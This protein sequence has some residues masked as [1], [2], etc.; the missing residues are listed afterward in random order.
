MSWIPGIREIIQQPESPIALK[1]RTWAINERKEL[2]HILGSR[3]FDDN[4]D[5]YKQ[6]AVAVL[7]ERDPRFDLPPEE[8]Y[9]ASIHGKVL[10]YSSH[11]RKGLAESLALIGSEPEALS[12]CST[13][14]P[15][16]IATLTIREIFADSD[17]VLWGSLDNLLPL[18]A[19]AAPTEFL[20]VV[21]AALQQTPC[22][23]DKLFSQEGHG[24]TG[25]NYLTGLLW[26]LETLAWDEQYLVR[27]S[28]ILGELAS[29]DPGGNWS[30][31]PSNSL[32]T[33]FLPWL[34]QTIAPID[35]R[36]VALQTLQKEFPEIAWGLLLSLLPS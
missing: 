18:L 26:A 31:R 9:A 11:L 25:G 12:N 35:K 29:H 32:T 13:N 17:W 6:C 14:K 21:E 5:V 1:N 34:P 8:R 22:P 16:I 23:F 24:I 19:E 15:E 2:W 33:I 28:V 27:V 4:L 30:N 7:T 20:D 36:K 3:L 10:K